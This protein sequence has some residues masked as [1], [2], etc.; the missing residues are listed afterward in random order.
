MSWR[1]LINMRKNPIGAD[2]EEGD[3]ADDPLV[4]AIYLELQSINKRSDKMLLVALVIS[5]GLVLLIAQWK[6]QNVWIE[7]LEATVVLAIVIG[8]IYSVVRQKQNIAIKHGLVCSNCGNRPRVQTII[9]AATTK[10]CSKC[11]LP[12][13]VT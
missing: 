6:I 7:A 12:L 5:C 13:N 3:I 4:Y 9:S 2:D 11:G 1:K 10:R 8:T